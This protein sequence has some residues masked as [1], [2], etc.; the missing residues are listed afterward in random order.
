MLVLMPTARQV[1]QRRK[2]PITG[3]SCRRSCAMRTKDDA[4]L[5]SQSLAVALNRVG[6]YHAECSF[7]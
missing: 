5:L 1:S 6:F 3:P 2:Y 7:V 4:S